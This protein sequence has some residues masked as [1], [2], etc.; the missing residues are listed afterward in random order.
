M[1]RNAIES[2]FRSSRITY[3]QVKAELWQFVRVPHG[4]DWTTVHLKCLGSIMYPINE[5]TGCIKKNV[6][7]DIFV[8]I[9]R[10]P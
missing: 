7:F 5:Y 10:F 8:V 2:D 1:A 3:M 6:L 9:S 4:T